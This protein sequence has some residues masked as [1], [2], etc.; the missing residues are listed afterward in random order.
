MLDY[1][2]KHIF[3]KG[4]IPHIFHGKVFWNVPVRGKPRFIPRHVFSMP[5]V[6]TSVDLF[7]LFK[8]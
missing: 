3:S 2:S 5:C 4:L 6:A 1:V 8:L 7:K